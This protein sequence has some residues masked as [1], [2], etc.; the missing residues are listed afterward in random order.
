[1]VYVIM[2]GDAVRVRGATVRRGLP[3]RAVSFKEEEKT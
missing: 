3:A 2:S 1:M